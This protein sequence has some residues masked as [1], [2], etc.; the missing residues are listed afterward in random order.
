MPR[1]CRPLRPDAVLA[2]PITTTLSLSS[3]SAERERLAVLS[4]DDSAAVKSIDANLKI[5][6]KSIT[7]M[8]DSRLGPSLP[9]D[10]D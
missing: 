4:D 2:E 1:G 5:I 10:G 8:V 3:L 7:W 9:S 6:R